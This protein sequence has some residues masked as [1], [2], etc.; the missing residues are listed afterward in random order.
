MSKFKSQLRVVYISIKKPFQS[1]RAQLFP[2]SKTEIPKNKTEIWDYW[3]APWKFDAD[4]GN[5]PEDYLDSEATEARTRFLLK[6]VN[7]FVNKDDSTLEIG[8]NVGRNLNALYLNGFRNLSGIEINERAIRILGAS[9]PEMAEQANLF[10]SPVE[11]VITR[12]G[13]NAYD[14]VF[15]M[16][17]LMHLHPES[18]WVFAE[19]VRITKKHLIL[20][21]H[22]ES[23]NWRVFRRNYVNV[24]EPLGMRQI[25]SYKC[26]GRDVVFA[27]YYT[28]VFEKC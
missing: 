5:N 17:V 9:Y 20:I 13:D 6:I 4:G 3:K 26:S 1:L 11:D 12:L 27:G 18:E 22:E 19:I 2:K 15:T 7:K 16:A 14:A 10:N 21:E 8:C 28:R 24:F 25:C 23:Q